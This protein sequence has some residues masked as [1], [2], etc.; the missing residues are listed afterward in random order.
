[1]LYQRSNWSSIVDWSIFSWV[2][3][4]PAFHISK[5]YGQPGGYGGS[6]PYGSYL[7]L[8]GS[9]YGPG[10]AYRGTSWGPGY[11]NPNYGGYSAGGY[12][13]GGYP[14]GIIGGGHIGWG[15]H[16]NAIDF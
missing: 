12:P 2:S 1:M 6:S 14:G 15:S 8:S 10:S 4:I 11:L 5:E 3:L 9:I 7:G 16:I 13:A